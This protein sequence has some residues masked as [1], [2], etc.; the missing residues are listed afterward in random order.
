MNALSIANDIMTLTT[1]NKS[2]LFVVVLLF[3]FICVFQMV[4]RGDWLAKI[5]GVALLIL[6][7]HFLAGCSTNPLGMTDRTRLRTDAAVSI[8][9]ADEAARIAESNAKVI[10][11]QSKQNGETARTFAWVGM[12]P[13]SLG[14]VCGTFLIFT[15]LAIISWHM[16][17]TPRSEPRQ[18]NQV[19]NVHLTDDQVRM[20]QSHAERTGQQLIKRDGQFYLS[21]GQRTVKALLK[22]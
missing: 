5:L 2:A 22:G 8:A 10:V 12:I 9:Q 1:T 14:I 3:G 7:V 15:V 18:I 20:L 17:I 16:G 6:A 11:E 19:V 4:S 21:D 13:L